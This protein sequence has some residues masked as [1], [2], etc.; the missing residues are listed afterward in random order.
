MM[1]NFTIEPLQEKHL[2]AVY[3]ISCAAFP[4][5]WSRED[6]RR[7]IQNHKAINLVILADDQ[8]AGYLQCWYSYE[9]ADLINIAVHPDFRRRHLARALLLHLIDLLKKKDVENVFL[10]VR[11]SNLPAQLLYRSLGFITLS[12]RP[13]YYINGE[14]ALVMNLQI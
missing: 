1:E 3:D 8:V 13:R 5:P 7:E 10:E 11:V 6:L 9:D 12:R 4:L 2:D 14:D